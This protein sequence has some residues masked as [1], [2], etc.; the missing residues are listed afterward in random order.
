V[1]LGALAAFGPRIVQM[2]PLL[3]GGV[4]KGLSL[5][6]LNE[7]IKGVYGRGIRKQTLV[8][9]RRLIKGEIS[10]GPIL[11]NL[12][13]NAIPNINRLPPALTRLRRNL[14][15]IVRVTGIQTD[16]DLTV[17]QFVTVALDTAIPREEIER[18]AEDAIL[19]NQSEYKLVIT[20]SQIQSGSRAGPAGIL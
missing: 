15:F 4:A 7:V 3:R 6:A 1:A 13:R 5:N 19:T 12:K 16:T 8:D 20:R 9:V 18:I 11:R 10:S 14:S 2:L 17:D